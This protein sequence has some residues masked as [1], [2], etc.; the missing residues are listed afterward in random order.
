MWCI[1]IVVVIT[2]YSYE[3]NSIL[4]LQ[5]DKTHL[6]SHRY[7]TLSVKYLIKVDIDYIQCRVIML[8][9]TSGFLD[10]QIRN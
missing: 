10:C 2:F 6:E 4:P 5:K 8:Q 3:T 9:Y 1:V 7:D